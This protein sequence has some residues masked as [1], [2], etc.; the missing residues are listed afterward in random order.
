MKNINRI[1]FFPILS[2]LGISSLLYIQVQAKATK[3]AIPKADIYIVP[4]PSSLA[5]KLRYPG[6]VI[7]FKDIKVVARVSGV[8][9]EKYFT[10]GQAVKKGDLLYKIEDKIYQA[11]YDAATASVNISKAALT[12]TKKALNR[13]KKLYK[14]KALS[15]EQEDNAL[16]AYQ[17]A[18]ATL[19]LTTAQLHQAKID[20]DYTQV[21]APISGIIG[22]TEVD[23][24]DFVNSNP[25]QV[26]VKITQNNFVYVSFSV[27]FSDYKNIKNGTWILVDKK[28]KVKVEVNGKITSLEGEIDYI[29]MNIDKLTSVVKMRAKIENSDHALMSGSFVRV[30]IQNVIKENVITVPQKAIIQDPLGTNIYIEKDG[31]V[32]L[33]PVILGRETGDNYVIKTRVI[34]S[35]EGK[36]SEISNQLKSGDR[37]IINNFFRL[38][39]GSKVLVDKVI[40][41]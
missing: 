30:L 5:I 12:N 33:K 23:T 27:P 19:E 17:Q 11:K 6:E 3:P 22:L 14:Q 37:V 39:P 1:I 34:E 15:I 36:S 4:A 26:L 38:K 16:S 13:T 40:N 29:N 18:L 35:S 24:G 28:P 10:E 8:L 20:L 25:P 7:S 32:K 21:K 41:K 2:I 9:E 31:I